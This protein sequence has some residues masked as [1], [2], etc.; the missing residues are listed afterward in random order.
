MS[1]IIY[2]TI[3]LYNKENNILPYLYIGSD[4]YNDPKYLGSSKDLIKDIKKIGKEH[5]EKRILCEFNYEIDNV[6]LRKIESNI[7]KSIDVANDPKYYNKTNSSHKGYVETEEQRKERMKKTHDG[8]R[9]WW[10]SLDDEKKQ[11]RIKK[12]KLQSKN[13]NHIKGKTYEEIYGEEVGKN[14]REKKKGKNNGMS[15]SI[16]D[17]QT[18]QVFESMV[19]AMKHYGIKKHSTLKNRCNKG[20]VMKFI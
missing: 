10:D 16:I 11:E 18:G 3:N 2:E 6:T 7:Q 15:K 17:V 14:K 4:Q 19:E 9:K 8:Y 13:N 12:L 20:N 1:S 5:F